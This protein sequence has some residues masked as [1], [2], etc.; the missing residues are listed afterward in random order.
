MAK[1]ELDLF[2]QYTPIRPESEG[3]LCILIVL[4]VHAEECTGPDRSPTGGAYPS[5]NVVEA[6]HGIRL[7][8]P[9]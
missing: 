3:E 5:Q 4:T 7:T 1:A 6:S 9:L 2:A 8:V